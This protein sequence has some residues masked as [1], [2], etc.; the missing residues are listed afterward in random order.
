[1][2]FCRYRFASGDEWVT[3]DEVSAY[4]GRSTAGRS[5]DFRL[6]FGAI[7]HLDY[8]LRGRIGWCLPVQHPARGRAGD[9][10]PISA[11]SRAF[12]SDSPHLRYG[13]YSPRNG[14]ARLACGAVT[15]W[16]CWQVRH[17][18][19]LVRLCKGGGS[20]F[21]A[22]PYAP[23]CL[24]AHRSV[25]I[26]V[27]DFPAKRDSPLPHKSTAAI[28]EHFSNGPIVLIQALHWFSTDLT[29]AKRIP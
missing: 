26:P 22:D 8:F 2:I 17:V 23:I 7:S 14:C 4:A 21:L 6:L 28:F 25:P 10:W 12:A 5:L 18:L 11:T 16:K 9:C 29:R 1:M 24:P 3:K 19:F 15:R 20:Y 27:L 13:C